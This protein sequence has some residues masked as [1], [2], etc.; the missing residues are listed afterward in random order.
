MISVAAVLAVTLV[1]IDAD[2]DVE[3]VPFGELVES[4]TDSGVE[5]FVGV[6]AE[7]A[8]NSALFVPLGVALRLHGMTLGG[9]A[10]CGLALSV[11][12]EVAQL[13]IVSGR[14]T[15]VDDVLLNTLGVVLGHVVAARLVRART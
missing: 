7:L 3:L 4:I 6:I 8:A 12:V 11:A 13:L 10:A 15:A 2:N 9:T 5:R 1:P 14:T